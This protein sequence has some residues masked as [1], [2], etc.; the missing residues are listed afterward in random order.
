MGHTEIELFCG[1]FKTLRFCLISSVLLRRS[2][3]GLRANNCTSNWNCCE[4]YYPVFHEFFGD[5]LHTHTRTHTHAPTHTRTRTHTHTHTHTT[6]TQ[7]IAAVGYPRNWRIDGIST[8][9]PYTFRKRALYILQKSPIYS[10]KEPYISST[11][12]LYQQKSPT[13]P[14]NDVFHKRAQYNLQKSPFI[15]F[16]SP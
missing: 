2:F 14:I 12:R 11:L 8:K 5:G 7:E 6:H 3:E 13:H 10:T 1:I 4:L 15:P 16:K 9:E